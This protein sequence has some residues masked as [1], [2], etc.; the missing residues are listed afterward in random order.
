MTDR[1]LNLTDPATILLW[2][3]G[4]VAELAGRGTGAEAAKRVAPAT[5]LSRLGLAAPDYD[6]LQDR[7]RV[8]VGCDIIIQ[9]G[10]RV[11][12]VADAILAACTRE[13]R[14]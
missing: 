6:A 9:T 4:T 2:V 14:A 1:A 8:A 12:E 5:R 11:Q 3:P 10:A 13:G 7:I